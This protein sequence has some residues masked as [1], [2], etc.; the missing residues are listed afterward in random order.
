MCS[1]LSNRS[2]KYYFLQAASLSPAYLSI[3]VHPFFVQPICT[4]FFVHP[5]FVHPLLPRDKILS[6]FHALVEPLATEKGATTFG[7]VRLLRDS[8][9]IS[10]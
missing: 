7:S 9:F 3:F 4:P 8:P 1:K 5:I 2:E 6:D 10:S